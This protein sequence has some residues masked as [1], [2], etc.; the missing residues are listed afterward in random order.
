MMNCQKHE[1]LIALAV[2]GDLSD[3]EAA[4]VTTHLAGC[5][6]C[7]QFAVESGESQASLRRAG[8]D[9][10]AEAT[11]IELRCAVMNEIA[12][13]PQP[14]IFWSRFFRPLRW[15]YATLAGLLI[16]FAPLLL[17]LMNAG[18]SSQR[19]GAGKEPTPNASAQRTVMNEN[20]VA[21]NNEAVSPPRKSSSRH[22]PARS[23]QSQ[24]KYAR[25][26]VISQPVN[27]EAAFTAPERSQ[28]FAMPFA[29]E[30]LIA[31]MTETATP[32]DSSV[33][34]ESTPPADNKLR[35]E[36]QTRDP[37]IR[38]IWFVNKEPRR[39]VGTE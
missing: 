10:F 1:L 39:V 28:P 32:A 17:Y 13:R 9:D 3:R 29:D 2:E 31:G 18:H 8:F 15:Q 35:M 36:I 6:T 4:S 24:L 38:I 22:Q 37:N 34:V 5:A 21:Q 11:L 25:A 12:L 26:V 19:P 20:T 30:Q 23:T 27:Q 16:L 33:E 14:N 7:R